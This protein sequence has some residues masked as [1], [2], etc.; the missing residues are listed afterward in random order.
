MKR[1]ELDQFAM[2]SRH[3][4][5]IICLNRSLI[6]QGPPEVALSPENLMAAYGPE[7]T[8]YHHRHKS[9]AHQRHDRPTSL[10]CC[11]FAFT[12][13]GAPGKGHWVSWA[14]CWGAL[15][16]VVATIPVTPSVIQLCWASWGPTQSRPD[17]LTLLPQSCSG[18]G[19]VYLI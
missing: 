14:G 11:G 9:H 6:C 4:D 18:L 8:R 1:S 2:V 13:A 3:C 5:Q 12:A 7:V 16:S 17:A 19:V 15:T 10:S